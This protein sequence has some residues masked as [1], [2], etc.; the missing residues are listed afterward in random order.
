VSVD[1]APN[2]VVDLRVELEGKVVYRAS[3]FFQTSMYIPGS[4]AFGDGIVVKC[5][6][7]GEN[8][9]ES[10]PDDPVVLGRACSYAIAAR[11]SAGLRSTNSGTVICPPR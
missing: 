9:D 1:A 3:G 7:A 4:A 11:D 8:V 5:G 2:Y 10:D 6:R